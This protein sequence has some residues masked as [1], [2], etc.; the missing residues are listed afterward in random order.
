MQDYFE[1]LR[2]DMT[3]NYQAAQNR[4]AKVEEG[5]LSPIPNNLLVGEVN[6]YYSSVLWFDLVKFSDITKTGADNRSAALLLNTVI[7]TVIKIICDFNGTMINTSGDQVIAVFGLE[8]REAVNGAKSA[9]QAA[10]Y[11]TNFIEHIADRFIG[12]MLPNGLRCS[13]GIDQGPVHISAVGRRG[14]N[15]LVVLGPPVH[16]AENL[17]FLAGD[18]EI[19]VGENVYRSL[20]H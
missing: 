1:I 15:A 16:I 8:E 12:R 19:W 11:A 4:M 13:T 14:T 3:S 9:L 10:L 7:P 20:N 17:H 2:D 6:S 18:N 5:R